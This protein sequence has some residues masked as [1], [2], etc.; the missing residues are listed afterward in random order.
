[1]NNNKDNLI[2]L[3][4]FMVIIVLLI[5][6]LICCYKVAKQDDLRILECKEVISYETTC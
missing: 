2:A 4:A 3:V 1:M 5:A 6:I